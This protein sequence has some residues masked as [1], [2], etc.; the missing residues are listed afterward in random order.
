M[1][2]VIKSTRKVVVLGWHVGDIQGSH[3]SIAA[4]GH[5]GVEREIRNTE[6][7]GEANIYF[8]A[9][10]TGEVKVTVK[11]SK[12]GEDTATLHVQ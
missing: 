9:D 7:D 3:A 11:G 10:Y 5:D 6:N 4:T 1:T 12:S 8:P 2:L